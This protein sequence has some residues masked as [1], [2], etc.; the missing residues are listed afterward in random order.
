MKNRNLTSKMIALAVVGAG[1]LTT[2]CKKDEVDTPTIDPNAGAV[3]HV[4]YGVG[5]SGTAS[6]YL[7][8]LT[9]LKEGN[10]SFEGQ[11]KAFE[12]ARTH[13]LYASS[14]GKFLYDLEYGNGK[15][16]K[17]SLSGDK[18]LYREEKPLDI[19]KSIGTHPRWRVIDDKNALL[20]DVVPKHKDKTPS[21]NTS[22]LRIVHISLPDLT[23]GEVKEV[24]LPAGISSDKLPDAH[25]WRVDN[26]IIHNGKAYIGTAVQGYDKETG[27]IIP[28]RVY[29]TGESLISHPATTLVLDFPSFENPKLVH[30]ELANGE[31][32][33]YRAPSFFTDEAGD[34]YNITME[35]SHI[36]KMNPNTG[37]YDNTYKFDLASKLGLT[38]IGGT[39]I[40]YAGKGIAYLPYYDAAIGS[41][42][43]EATWGVARVDLKA[44]T[45]IKMN[46][47]EKLWLQYYQ[48]AK[49]GKDGKLYMAICP[50][51][52]TGNIY[53]FD[54]TKADP[55]GFEKGATLQVSGE[56]F[57]MGVY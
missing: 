47:P 56:G 5:Y 17:Y 34:V 26:A 38:K 16:V 37:E 23:L 40:F 28:T 4:G 49:L 11:G 53:I 8:P 27:K 25:I 50:T 43:N 20:F 54:P 1:L 32:Y 7:M 24:D 51:K 52:G 12:K 33:G 29:G 2:S 19:S 3:F 9:N 22:T 36:L 6:A 18:N 31:N 10:L 14:D 39:G 35:D 46:L 30:S 21:R 15:I 45:V 55:N 48:S 41:K 13:R 42:A 57:Y 44:K